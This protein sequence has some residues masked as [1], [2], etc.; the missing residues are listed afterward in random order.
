MRKIINV[1]IGKCTIDDVLQRTIAILGIKGTGKTTLL[2]SFLLK[3]WNIFY[4]RIPFL[5]LDFAGSLF[6]MI[7]ENYS[8]TL[9]LEIEEG[10]PETIGFVIKNLK[11]GIPQVL[12]IQLP[13]FE[14]IDFVNKL[15][16]SLLHNR[17]ENFIL[18]IDEIH[19]V[20]P[21]NRREGFSHQLARYV[22]VCRN[23]NVGVI[24]TSQRPS[25]V[26][27][28]FLSLCD[29]LVLMK[30][31]SKQDLSYIEDTLEKIMDSDDVKNVLRGLVRLE[32][33]EM[34]IIKY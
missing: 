9:L 19:L 20:L 18:A 15:S 13:V 3:F 12:W 4:W 27:K 17:S 14:R 5:A 33:G 6:R 7:E 16:M 29:V 25:F 21:Q 24:A 1:K 26:S 34:F 2:Y 11:M 30:M 23:Y 31:V 8:K 22:S 10:K 28:S 32:K